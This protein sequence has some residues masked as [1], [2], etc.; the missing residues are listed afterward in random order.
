MSAKAA[1]GIGLVAFGGL[2]AWWWFHRGE[3]PSTGGAKTYP[4]VP[5]N[6]PG[7]TPIPAE[8]PSA[9]TPATPLGRPYVPAHPTPIGAPYV[10]EAPSSEPDY[11]AMARDAALD[12]GVP[13][14]LFLRLIERESN[15]NPNAVSPTGDIGIAQLNPR[16]HPRGVAEDP[17]QALPYAAK[18]LKRMFGR[19]GTWEKALAAYNWGPTNLARTGIDGIPPSVR[20]YIDAIMGKG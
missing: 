6:I 8:E 20:L 11:R 19:F 15:F 17:A 2:G 3:A 18:Y 7:G 1:L 4:Y 10:P 16:F 14:E 9:P 13:P 12:N 5:Y